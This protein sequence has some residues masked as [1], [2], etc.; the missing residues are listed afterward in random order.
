MND[1]RTDHLSGKALRI[2]QKVR[3]MIHEDKD[4]EPYSGGGC[5]AFYTPEEWRDRGE[6]YGTDSVLI[7]CHD[8]GDLAL[9]C[10]LD[11][12]YYRGQ[13]LLNFCLKDIGYYYEPCTSWYSAVYP[14]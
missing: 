12:A 8:G 2:A 4:G 1:F 9:Y 14:L 11:Y 6:K 5:R 3:E 13:K 7:L 10:N